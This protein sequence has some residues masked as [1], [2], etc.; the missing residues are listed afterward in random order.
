MPVVGEERPHFFFW[1]GQLELTI[2]RYQ[3]VRNPDAQF[4]WEPF[5]MVGWPKDAS[6]WWGGMILPPMVI[7]SSP[8]RFFSFR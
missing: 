7:T 5:V 6:V 3:A 8:F 1:G 4:E 2:P